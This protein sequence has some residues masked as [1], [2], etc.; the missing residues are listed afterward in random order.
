[1]AVLVPP[2]APL[3]PLKPTRPPV[4]GLGISD[5]KRPSGGG[6]GGNGAS[7]GRGG[8]L[9]GP[10]TKGIMGF[11]QARDQGKFIGKN[12]IFTAEKVIKMPLVHVRDCLTVNRQREMIR[13]ESVTCMRKDLVVVRSVRK[14]V[15]FGTKYKFALFIWSHQKC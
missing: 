7:M 15:V 12:H 11:R 14:S 9:D 6:N 1:M 10:A 4:V 8:S 3:P 5:K 2:Q 13:I